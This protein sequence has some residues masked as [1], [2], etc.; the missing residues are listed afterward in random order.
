VI[1]MPDT[2]VGVGDSVLLRVNTNGN[3]E[4]NLK[5]LWQISTSGRTD[6]LAD[7]TI[8][9]VFK[10]TGVVSIVIRVLNNRGI[11][12]SPYTIRISVI[13]K[14]KKYLMYSIGNSHTYDFEPDR[15]FREIVSAESISFDNGWH[16][17]CGSWLYNTWLYP[18]IVC[19]E[20]LSFGKYP[21]ALSSFPWDIITIQ[22]FVGTQGFLEKKAAIDFIDYALGFQ[23]VDSVSFFLYCTWPMNNSDPLD[24]FDFSQAWL[25]PYMDENDSTIIS[26]AFF[27][28]LVDGVRAALPAA[29]VKFIPVGEVFYRFH[30]SAKEGLI[31]GFSGA[32]ELYRDSW[33]LNNVGRYIASLTVFCVVFNKNPLDVSDFHGFNINPEQISDKNITL[34]QKN[35]FRA[36]ISQVI[37]SYR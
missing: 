14:P 29:K 25:K 37:D 20:P 30:E 33:H 36:I 26:R 18:D 31:P 10:D 22:P 21:S 15:G 34:E 24:S 2:V 13:K 5:Y 1:G 6:T 19:I 12:S 8:R 32:G 7:T 35:V 16:I 27:S 11:V 28:Y 4:N 9:V 17:H 3:T 23:N